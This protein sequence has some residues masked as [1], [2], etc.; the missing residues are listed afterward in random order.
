MLRIRK[1]ELVAVV[2]L[3]L[4]GDE[5]GRSDVAAVV[6]ARLVKAAVLADV[7]VGGAVV[8]EFA[9]AGALFFAHPFDAAFVAEMHA[10]DL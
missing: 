2:S 8:A 3:G 1:F 10:S 5:F 4:V 6:G 7:Q 9:V